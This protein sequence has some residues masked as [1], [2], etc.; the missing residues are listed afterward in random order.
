MEMNK[1]K[2]VKRRVVNKSAFIKSS[3]IKRVILWCAVVVV[4][5]LGGLSVDRN[6]REREKRRWCAP[7]GRIL[8][9]RMGER[10]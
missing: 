7:K 4:V 3:R 8:V 10:R 6:P 1:K 9:G 5:S 2:R